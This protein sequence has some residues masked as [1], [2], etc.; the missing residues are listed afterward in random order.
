M[1]AV[2][3][4]AAAAAGL[5]HASRVRP[6]VRSRELASATVT[7]SSTPSKDRARPNR[8]AVVQVA[9]ERTPLLPKPEL[10]EAVAPAPSSKPRVSTGDTAGTVMVTPGPGLS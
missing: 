5:T 6:L 2:D 8:P 1:R 7:Q 9:P 3:Q 4:S 10:S